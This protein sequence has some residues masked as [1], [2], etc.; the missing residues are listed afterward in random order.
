MIVVLMVMSGMDLS[1]DWVGLV[2]LDLPGLCLVSLVH[3]M[4]QVRSLCAYY[5]LATGGMPVSVGRFFLQ[6]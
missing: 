3:G 5:S 2:G 6:V 1:H 4:Q